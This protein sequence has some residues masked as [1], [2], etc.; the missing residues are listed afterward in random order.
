MDDSSQSMDKRC[1]KEK[2]K[3]RLIVSVDL[4]TKYQI[5]DLCKKI[6]NSVS[7]LKLGYEV[8]YNCG[9]E[10]IKT[11]NSFGYKVM[12]DAKLHDIPNTVKAALAAILKL[13][14]TKITLH[15]SGGQNMLLAAKEIIKLESSKHNRIAPKLFAVTVL[16]SL[17]DNDLK[18][19]GFSKNQL[20]SV[21]NLA[22]L[23]IK[24]GMDG[25]VCSPN[26]VLPIREKFGYNFY[27]ATPGIRMEGGDSHDQKRVS[28]P[29]R[30]IGNG[31][32][33][34]IMGRSIIASED[35][36]RQLQLIINEIERALQ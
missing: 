28:T 25:I 34:L 16:T 29:E 26:E 35:P 17:D 24:C 19:I 31:A 5:I 13:G 2:I 36:S 21:L 23:A 3:D 7:T 22:G 6:N 33:Y 12:L 20:D 14:V 11:V 30:A 4:N 15:A 8:I 18:E 10:I 27:I 32:D 9:L 1:N